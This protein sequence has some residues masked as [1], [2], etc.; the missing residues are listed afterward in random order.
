MYTYRVEEIMIVNTFKKT[1]LKF[2]VYFVLL[3]FV[4]MI[5]VIPNV[6]IKNN[7]N[8]PHYR[9]R[10]TTDLKYVLIWNQT[11]RSRLGYQIRQEYEYTQ[12]QRI[13]I[14]QNCSY[15]NC[16]I[17]YDKNIL[18][19][20]GEFDAVVF[21]VEDISRVYAQEINLTRSKFQ[22]YIFRSHESSEKYP[23]CNPEFDD[24]FNWTW[25]YKL[26]S[27][28]P[29]PFFNIYD[30]KN[31]IIGP[32]K[33]IRWIPKMKHDNRFKN[34][35]K[36]KDRAVAWVVD[37]CKLKT[38]YQH[39]IKEL[40]NELKGYNYSLDTYGPCSKNK[41]PSGKLLKCYKMFEKR[42]FF[43]LVLEESFAKDYVSEKIVKA[44][45]HVVIP[46]VSGGANYTK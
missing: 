44:L 11:K 37:K 15:I 36:T 13:F 18:P 31:I 38:K 32:K 1:I 19:S 17:T 35:I 8:T 9:N 41:C 45:T 14:K 5:S 34:I 21:N 30:V 29:N 12:G 26:D 20:E 23:I 25:T 7:Q 24:F 16:Y 4:I 42:Y 28:I 40:S 33:S 39:F 46:I 43:H 22:K 6:L 3:M 27:D 2:S 10:F